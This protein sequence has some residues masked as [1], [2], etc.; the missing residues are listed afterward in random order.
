[1][2]SITKITVVAREASEGMEN[3]RV[4]SNTLDIGVY[5]DVDY[6]NRGWSL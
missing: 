5:T 3:G 2:G 6:S 4:D 1:M